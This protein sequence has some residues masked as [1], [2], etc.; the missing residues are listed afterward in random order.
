MRAALF[1]FNIA[2][3]LHDF[4]GIYHIQRSLTDDYWLSDSRYISKSDIGLIAKEGQDKMLVFTNSIKSAEPMDA[5]NVVVYG[6]NNQV[7]GMGTT[8][9]DGV[10]EIEYSRKEFTGFPTFDDDCEINR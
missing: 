10:A 9:A 1:T 5:L 7:L 6:G 3:N 8:N 4:K 2:D